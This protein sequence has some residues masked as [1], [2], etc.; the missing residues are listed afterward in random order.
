M[1][2]RNRCLIVDPDLPQA[3]HVSNRC[4]RSLF[5]LEPGAHDRGDRE[6]EDHRKELLLARLEK[7][8]AVSSI[9]VLAFSVMGNHLHL[10]LRNVP[11]VG[12]A[13]SPQEV[14]DRWLALHPL[15]NRQ[16]PRE[17]EPGELEA[18]VADEAWVAATRRKLM[19]LSQFMKEL[20]QHV[21]VEVNKL[22]RGS[23]AF[24]SGRYKSK[25]IDDPE[26]HQLV[27]SMVYVDL[28]P[29]AAGLCDRPEDGRHTS[30]EGRLGRDQP[31]T[32]QQAEPAERAPT[33]A[34]R[35]SRSA[36]WLVPLAGEDPR[37]RM[38]EAARAASAAV[39]AAGRTVLAGLTLRRYLRLVDAV[40]RLLRAGK[41][42]LDRR[43]APILER[44]GLGPEDLRVGFARM[45]TGSPH[46]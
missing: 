27:R 32:P 36:S 8:A 34:F 38:H 6:P 24:W 37:S 19:D 44:V 46:F 17:P 20:K 31:A 9:E 1:P 33:A 18:L 5:L 26:G 35:R 43:L 29:L 7:L 15:R 23:G 16:G 28:N 2:R 30:L 39:P 41:A 4:A 40:S 12:H 21:A 22:E 13:W 14:L 45:A 10:V 11:E 42:S 25:P 3:W